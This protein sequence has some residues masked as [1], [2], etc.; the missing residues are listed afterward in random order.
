MCIVVQCLFISVL[1]L[2]ELLV[3]DADFKATL[4]V[5]MPAAVCFTPLL[6]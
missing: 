4:R 6:A 1:S 5:Q 2:H 3:T